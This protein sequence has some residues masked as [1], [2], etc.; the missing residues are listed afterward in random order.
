[1]NGG[2]GGGGRF[3]KSLFQVFRLCGWENCASHTHYLND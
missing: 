2:G 3:E 1:M